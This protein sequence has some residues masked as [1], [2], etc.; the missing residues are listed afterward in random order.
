MRAV[1][2]FV[3][4]AVVFV[5]GQTALIACQ[6][7]CPKPPENGADAGAAEEEGSRIKYPQC[8]KACVVLERL[9]CPEARK[10]DGG[11]N[12]YGVCAET[13]S[14]GKFDL[15]PECVGAASTLAEVRA[16][17]SVRCQK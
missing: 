5:L 13:V 14:S 11:L 10:L 1:N 2:L 7:P 3:G 16:C 17:G 15:K 12:C 8:V 4:L 9:D 6:A